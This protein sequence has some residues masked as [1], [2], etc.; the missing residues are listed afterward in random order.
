MEFY[1]IISYL[2]IEKEKKEKE[3]WRRWEWE[4]GNCL[5]VCRIPGKGGEDCIQLGCLQL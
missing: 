2:Q 3:R 4:C 1:E 5:S